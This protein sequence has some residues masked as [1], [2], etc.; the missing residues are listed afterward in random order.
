[1]LSWSW[2]WSPIQTD[3]YR[4][5]FS[6]TLKG[7]MNLNVKG[8]F[9]IHFFAAHEHNTGFHLNFAIL[10]IAL[11]SVLLPTSEIR[12]VHTAHKAIQSKM[13]A[14]TVHTYSANFRFSLLLHVAIFSCPCASSF[15]F[16]FGKDRRLSGK[17]RSFGLARCSAKKI[18]SM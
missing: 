13:N 8:S 3:N 5:T 11:V 12:P 1:M 9:S 14:N 6:R 7:D 10:S 18:T 17:Y 15:G 16:I 4:D 2:S